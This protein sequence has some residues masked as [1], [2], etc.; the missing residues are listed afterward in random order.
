MFLLFAMLAV[1][2]NELRDHGETLITHL[3]LVD[4]TGTEITGGSPAYARLAVTWVDDGDG[5]MRPSAD[6][7]FDIP[8]STSV[9][10]WRGY[11]A[12]TAGTNYGGAALTQEDFA[13][14]GQYKLLAA[15]TGIVHSST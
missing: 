12:L 9:A 13:A 5:V 8:A 14:Q 7:T 1:Y 3:G 10:G 11:S 4:E 15:T 6:L 2:L